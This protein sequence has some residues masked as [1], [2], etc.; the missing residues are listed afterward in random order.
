MYEFTLIKEEYS[1]KGAKPMRWIFNQITGNQDD[2]TAAL[3]E[4]R[5]THGI[6][7]ITMEPDA[8][9]GGIRLSYFGRVTVSCSIPRRMLKV[10]PLSKR[11]VEAKV[12]K[13]LVKQLEREGLQSV[14]KFWTGESKMMYR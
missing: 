10:L 1:P 11:K 6:A 13:S 12:S 7:R 9:T 4:S 5:K 14:Q 2:D 3:T 8:K